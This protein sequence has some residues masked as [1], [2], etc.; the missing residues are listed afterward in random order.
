MFLAEAYGKKRI[1][2]FHHLKRVLM[3]HKEKALSSACS[4]ALGQ[5]VQ[6]DS[7]SPIFVAFQNL[8]G[9]SLEQPYLALKLGQLLQKVDKMASAFPS[10]L[11]FSMTFIL[12]FVYFSCP[13]LIN[14]SDRIATIRQLFWCVL[15]SF[16]IDFASLRIHLINI[17]EDSWIFLNFW[18]LS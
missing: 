17:S 10:N 5:V 7:R 11:H 14:L 12:F 16:F 18:Q 4:W 13:V 2:N 9:D 8:L 15:V 1:G 6:R 3:G